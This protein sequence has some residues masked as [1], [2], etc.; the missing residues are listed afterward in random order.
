MTIPLPISGYVLAGGRSSRMGSDKAL[1]Q[2]A[3][4]PLIEHAVTKLRRVCAEVGILSSNPALAAYAPLVRDIHPNCGPIGGIEAALAHSSHDWNLI[5]PVDVPFLPNAILQ[6]WVAST[7][8]PSE[9]NRVAM[10]TVDGRPQPAVCLL[11]KEILPSIAAAVALGEFKLL[12]VLESAAE[13]L[14]LQQDQPLNRFLRYCPISG[15]FELFA[16]SGEHPRPIVAGT[17]P[18]ADYPWFAN[19]NT[20]EDLAIAEAHTDALDT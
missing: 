20:P 6:I 14:G 15:A 10:F 17:H 8:A 9:T 7:I 4:K 5:L 3:G 19:L 13:V 2:L 1:L 16:S 11:H 12:P 18:A